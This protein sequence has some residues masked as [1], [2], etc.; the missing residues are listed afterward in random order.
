MYLYHT[1]N[2]IN[3]HLATQSRSASFLTYLILYLGIRALTGA[4]KMQNVEEI[5]YK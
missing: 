4:V 1:N 5:I 2:S 3:A